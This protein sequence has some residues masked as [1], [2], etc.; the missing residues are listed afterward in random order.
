MV[1]YGD[2]CIA[3]EIVI[4]FFSAA[5]HVIARRVLDHAA[6][7][8]RSP[9]IARRSAVTARACSVEH[10]QAARA[11]PSIERLI[12]S[13][14][15][16]AFVCH[17][18]SSAIRSSQICLRRTEWTG[19]NGCSPEEAGR[20]LHVVWPAPSSLTLACIER[21]LTRVLYSLEPIDYVHNTIH[22]NEHYTA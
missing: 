1:H 2:R 4:V 15:S 14:K 21:I 16:R 12:I 8:S 7:E 17:P 20:C 5:V 19:C 6:P 3:C 11:P 18:H 13:G 22:T 9:L 10:W